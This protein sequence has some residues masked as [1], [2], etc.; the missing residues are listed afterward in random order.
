VDAFR[1]EWQPRAEIAA[2]VDC[3]WADRSGRADPLLPDAAVELV[4]SGRGL[5]VRG[6]DTCAH[7]VGSFPERTFVGARFRAGA[8]PVVLGVEGHELADARIPISSLWGRAEM[9]RLETQLADAD[10]PLAAAA[11]LEDA[12]AARATR[13]PDSAVA[14][15]V[16]AL[17]GQR[18]VRVSALADRLGLSDR[19]LRRRCI[20][21]LGFGP[22]M[23][24]RI[25]RFQ[26]FLILAAE[27]REFGLGELAATAGFA[28][29][30]HLTREC[31][32]LAGS[33]PSALRVRFLQDEHEHRVLP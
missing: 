20:S 12:I 27:R 31:A 26:R 30:P 32:D 7:A 19:Q 1:C 6:A 16:A 17:R 11:V 2:F 28:D 18:D 22:K 25:L 23:L 33:T 8:A 29:Q 10:S 13:A 15:V 24:H 9:E 4:W 14:E 3:L 21:A 5:F